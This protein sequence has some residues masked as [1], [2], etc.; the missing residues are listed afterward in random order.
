MSSKIFTRAPDICWRRPSKKGKSFA[1][2][3]AACAD[4]RRMSGLT[5]VLP[6]SPGSL[7]VGCG[8]PSAP[9][10]LRHYCLTVL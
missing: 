5:G 8:V 1:L 6:E 9:S 4:R 7:K 2:C 10:L 3:V